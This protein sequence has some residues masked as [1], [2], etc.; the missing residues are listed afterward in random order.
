MKKIDLSFLRH[1]EL[2]TKDVEVEVNGEVQIVTIKPVSG[3]GLTSLGLVNEDDVDRSSKMCLIALMYGLEIKQDE[4]EL[5]MNNETLAADSL[6]AEILKFTGEHS[7][8]LQQARR[9]V[10]KSSKTKTTK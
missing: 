6:A 9:E 7:S 3:R 5:F 10:K 2:P 1:K 8:E 4:A